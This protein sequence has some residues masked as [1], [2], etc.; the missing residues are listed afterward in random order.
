MRTVAP[1]LDNNQIVTGYLFYIRILSQSVYQFQIAT[2]KTAES[3]YNLRK[4][5]AIYGKQNE[6]DSGTK[7]GRHFFIWESNERLGNMPHDTGK[8]IKYPH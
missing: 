7:P 8:N 1:K 2:D 5:Y 4:R 6:H 3:C